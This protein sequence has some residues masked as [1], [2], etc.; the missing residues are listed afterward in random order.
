MNLISLTSRSDII[1]AI[2]SIMCF[3]HCVATPFIFVAHAGLTHGMESH[4]WWWGTIDLA[5]LIISFF[6][7]YWSTRN[8][9]KRWI[10]YA[11]WFSWVFLSL[12]LI[13]EKVGLW[14]LAEELIYLPT[15]GLISLHFY[16][17]RYCRCETDNCC[18]NP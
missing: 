9:T 7:V 13:N 11:F 12:I 15:L 5:F 6:A 2:A 8:T 4:P 17:R 14:H 18:A 16:N 10:K 3:V 1:G